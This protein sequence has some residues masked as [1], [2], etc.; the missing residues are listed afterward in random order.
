MGPV[1]RIMLGGEQGILQER[2]NGHGAHA[3]GDGRYPGDLVD[4]GLKVDVST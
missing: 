4:G 3:A 2:A 1:S